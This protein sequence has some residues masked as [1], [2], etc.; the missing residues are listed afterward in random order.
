[1][2]W[3]LDIEN[4]GNVRVHSPQESCRDYYKKIIDDKVETV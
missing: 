3:E 4:R 2:K 1:L